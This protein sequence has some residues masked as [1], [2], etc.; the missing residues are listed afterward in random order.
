MSEEDLKKGPLIKKLYPDFPEQRDLEVE[1]IYRLDT[2][3]TEEIIKRILNNKEGNGVF[4]RQK[5]LEIWGHLIIAEGQSECRPIGMLT[6]GANIGRDHTT[7]YLVTFYSK[8]R[9]DKR[10]KPN[11]VNLLRPYIE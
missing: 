2:P 1:E 6:C 10:I 7:L 11:L 8:T 9:R 5:G 3:S 4:F